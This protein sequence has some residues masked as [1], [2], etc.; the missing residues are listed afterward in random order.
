MAK[1]GATSLPKPGSSL[2]RATINYFLKYSPKRLN[3]YFY[4]RHLA[5][6]RKNVPFKR[7]LNIKGMSCTPLFLSSFLRS[8]FDP[9]FCNTLKRVRHACA[10]CQLLLFTFKSWVSIIL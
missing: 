3:V 2:E 7:V 10:Y 6:I 9:I 4:N 1:Y 5:N 8:C